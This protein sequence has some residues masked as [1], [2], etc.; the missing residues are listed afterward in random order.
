[1]DVTGQRIH[2]TTIKTERLALRAFSPSDASDIFDYS[3]NSN[4]TK[5]VFMY[6][7]KSVEDTLRYVFAFNSPR[8]VSWAMQQREEEKVK[9]IVFLHSINSH[10]QT[11]ELAY[12]VSHKYWGEGYATEAAKRVL[13]HCL[14]EIDMRLIEGTCLTDYHSSVR[15]LEK[16]GMTFQ[17][18]KVKA[19]QKNGL[20]YDL[21]YF[22][23]TRSRWLG[24]QVI[25]G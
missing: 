14:K 24:V 9:R 12:N 10:K 23:I 11:T 18:T 17:A 19:R 21:K 1:M 4:V 8:T 20:A 13:S 16:A 2:P 5:D 25:G 3:S 15:L 22:T 7:H 6:T